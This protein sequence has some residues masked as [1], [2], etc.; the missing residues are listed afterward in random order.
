MDQ[1][2]SIVDKVACCNQVY[3]L[4]TAAIVIA[5]LLPLVAERTVGELVT[6]TVILKDLP[7]V[8]VEISFEEDDEEEDEDYY[9]EEEEDDEEDAGDEDEEEGEDEEE[10]DE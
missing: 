10:I 9:G 3:V 4:I 8:D 7:V 6:G 5:S 2:K 1:V